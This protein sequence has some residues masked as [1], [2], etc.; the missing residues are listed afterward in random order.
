MQCQDPS[1]FI[2]ISIYFRNVSGW[3]L[4]KLLT[5]SSEVCEVEWCSLSNNFD[6]SQFLVLPSGSPYKTAS[7]KTSQY[8]LSFG[9]L[10]LRQYHKLQPQ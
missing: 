9:G 7:D 6:H 4:T 10:H 3:I 1:F 2:L 8:I 5:Q